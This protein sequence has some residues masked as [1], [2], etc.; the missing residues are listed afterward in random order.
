MSRRFIIGDIHAHFSLLEEVLKKAAFN[1]AED[2]LYSVG[3]FADRGPEP[4]KTLD[5]LMSLGPCFRPVLGNHD[6][7]LESWLFTDDPDP[8]WFYSNGGNITVSEI[9][10]QTKEWRNKLQEWLSKIPL[11]RIEER[12]IIIH[13]GIP[14]NM[15]ESELEAIAAEKRPV[16]LCLSEMEM[17]DLMS[18]RLDLTPYRDLEAFYWDREY[19]LSAMN[20]G[21]PQ[22][23]F[24]TMKD[25][26][27]KPL[28]TEK[29]IW[30]GHTQL[31]R[32]GQP[33]HSEKY[34]LYAI[35]TGCGSGR[36]PLTL[37][38]MD[39]LEYWQAFPATI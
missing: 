7:W 18:L 23:D 13:G 21:K 34:H 11:I 33:F 28:E 25:R 36:G 2:T 6:A 8:C 1:K 9:S 15:D 27:L 22:I 16:P 5:Y 32:T 39:S 24:R 14:R 31:Y 29:N 3:D 10:R 38:D 20:E 35:D 37:I 12:D 30:I 19:L 4:V 26:T 17:L